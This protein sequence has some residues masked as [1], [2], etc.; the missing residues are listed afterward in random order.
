MSLYFGTESSDVNPLSFNLPPKPPASAK[1]IR[2]FGDTKLCRT[3]ECMIEV[4][5]H[6]QPL[7]VGYDIED[8]ERWD[9][10]P[11]I[12]NQVQLDELIL[13]TGENQI[14]LDSNVEQL[15]LRKS[16]SSISPFTFSISPAYPNPFNPVLNIPL[17]L[18]KPGNLSV[19]VFDISGRVV[20]TIANGFWEPGTHTLTWSGDQFPSGVYFISVNSNGG[21]F[22]QKVLL[23][24]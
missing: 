11:V 16:T 3:D 23:L 8:G 1:D 9:I 17:V 21:V 12:E 6:G 19:S 4:M 7:I 2:F 20:D 10:I 18:V 24:R 14:T 15:I 13:L 22:R 5:N